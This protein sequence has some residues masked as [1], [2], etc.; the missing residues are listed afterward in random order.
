[1]KRVRVRVVLDTYFRSDK[2]FSSDAA[3]EA[4]TDIRVVLGNMG[5]KDGQIILDSQVFEVSSVDIREVE[6]YRTPEVL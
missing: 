3:G 5:M 4:A 1:M 6:D 2:A